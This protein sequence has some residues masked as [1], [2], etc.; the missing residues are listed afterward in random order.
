M[1]ACVRRGGGRRGGEGA[2]SFPGSWVLAR[3][4][5]LSVWR[6][7]REWEKEEEDRGGRR[8]MEKSDIGRRRKGLV[9]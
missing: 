5:F 6:I 9:G 1:F 8:S 4:M 7:E 3:S 2:I